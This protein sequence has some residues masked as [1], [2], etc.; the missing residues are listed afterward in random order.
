MGSEVGGAGRG[1]REGGKEGEERLSTAQECA[2]LPPEVKLGLQPRA[3]DSKSEAIPALA[4]SPC[5][6]CWVDG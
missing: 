6:S 5:L 1:G 3:P 4:A 2:W